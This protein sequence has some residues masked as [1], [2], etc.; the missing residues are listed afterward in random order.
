MSD[1]RLA[2]AARGFVGAL[3]EE[4]ASFWRDRDVRLDPN[5][6]PALR[7]EQIR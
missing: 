6:P 5:A 7:L 1:A 4:N 2:Q 3:A